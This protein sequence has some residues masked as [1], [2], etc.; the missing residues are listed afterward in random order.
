MLRQLFTQFHPE[1]LLQV[2]VAYKYVFMLVLFGFVT[3]YLPASVHNRCVYLLRRGGVPLCVAVL[4]AVIYIVIQVK[5]T[6]IQPF[7]YFQF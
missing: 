2:L 6:D 1:L 5:S 4:V 7:I 3:H